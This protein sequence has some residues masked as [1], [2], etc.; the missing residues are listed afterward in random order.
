MGHLA[1]FI[2]ITVD[3]RHEGPDGSFDFW[4]VD[5]PEFEQFSIDQLDRADT[6]VFGRTTFEGMAAYWPSEDVRTGSPQLA[7]RMNDTPKL[8]VS[9]TLTSTEWQP[10][11]IVD[12][13]ARVADHEGDALVLGSNRLVAALAD[14]HLLDE[15]RL[16]VNP[17]AIGSG[18][19][20]LDGLTERLQLK[21]LDVDRFD[22]GNVLLTYGGLD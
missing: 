21:L 11:T 20:V 8:V 14:A 9:R 10:T 7:Q 13:L 22:S 18:S 5:N 16:M 15:L 2:M 17:V 1:A 19:P 6:L 12:D 4:N 3:G